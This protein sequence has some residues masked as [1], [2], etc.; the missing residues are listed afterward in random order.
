MEASESNTTNQMEVANEYAQEYY[1]A[2]VQTGPAGAGIVPFADIVMPDPD[3]LSD[4][5][6]QEIE[7]AY[8]AELNQ[9]EAFYKSDQSSSIRGRM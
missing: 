9:M 8:I 2:L 5:S 1:N 4:M 7:A 3:Q 6:V